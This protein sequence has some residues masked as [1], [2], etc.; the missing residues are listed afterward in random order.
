MEDLL[1]LNV[2][3]TMSAM[4]PTV[5]TMPMNNFDFLDRNVFSSAT[6][7]KM[8]SVS[9]GSIKRISMMDGSALCGGRIVGGNISAIMVTEWKVFPVWSLVVA[10]EQMTCQ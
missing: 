6:T 3:G 7:P 1:D 9:D 10:A 4:A 2:M 5:L 8:E